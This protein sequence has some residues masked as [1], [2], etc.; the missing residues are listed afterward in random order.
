VLLSNKVQCYPTNT[1]LHVLQYIIFQYHK[2]TCF[3]AAVPSSD[4]CSTQHISASVRTVTFL[5][6]L[7]RLSNIKIHTNR[8]Q[9]KVNMTY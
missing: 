9:V 7:Y 4:P 1:T 2:V 5:S 6:H 3:G 8:N